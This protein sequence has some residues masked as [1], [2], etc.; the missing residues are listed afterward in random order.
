[1]GFT[2]LNFKR[3]WTNSEDFPTLEE[4]EAKVRADYQYHPDAVKDFLNTVLLPALEG[5]T[6]AANLGTEAGTSIEQRLKALSAEDVRLNDEILRL[7]GGGA[8]ESVKSTRVEFGEEN[9]TLVSADGVYRLEIP[10]SQHHRA[11]ASFGASI[12]SLIGG[13][14]DGGTW[15]A[16]STS[17]RYSEATGVVTLEAE[18]AYAGDVV[19]YGV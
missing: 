12:R 6:A 3:L 16:V 8:P 11:N 15:D 13:A 7:A 19:F 4:S 18:N 5:S 1:M 2:R 14:Y 10:A 9:W 17:W